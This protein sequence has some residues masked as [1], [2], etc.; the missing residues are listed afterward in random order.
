MKY[1]ECW[2]QLKKALAELHIEYGDIVYIASDVTLLLAEARKK[3]HVKTAE[4]RDEFL[5]EFIDML[6]EVVGD[7]GTLLFPVFSW[8]FCRGNG[9]D[10]RTT[11]GEVGALNNWILNNRADFARTQH[12][13]YSFMVWGGQSNS[14]LAM[15]NVDAFG[16]DSPFAYLH[17]HSGKMLLLNVSLQRSFTFMHYVEESVRVPYRYMKNFRGLY[18]DV[19][20][21]TSEKSYTMYVRDLEIESCEYIPD[22]ML[23]EKKIVNT[24]QLE[25]IIFKVFSLVDAYPIVADDLLHNHGSKC[26]KF[27]N[28][29]LEWGEGATHPDDIS[30]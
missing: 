25:N 5:N 9:F 17:Y 19:K 15:D 6:Q 3:Y 27:T 12:P 8:D 7:Q 2:R 1:V 23:E 26:Y 10:A 18:K 20:G 28:Y 24:A 29:R 22:E 13:I 30:N 11:M 16:E 14:L 21:D 4:Q